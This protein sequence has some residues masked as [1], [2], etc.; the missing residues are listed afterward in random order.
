MPT[1]TGNTNKRDVSRIGAKSANNQ[2]P[3]VGKVAST[4]SMNDPIKQGSFQNL[5]AIPT[6]D[7]LDKEK[8]KYMQL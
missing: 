1:E 7:E 6:K 3:Q 2:H 5:L 4:A 8:V